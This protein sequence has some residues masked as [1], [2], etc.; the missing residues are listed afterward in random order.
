MLTN[1]RNWGVH[2]TFLNMYE[3]ICIPKK[4]LYGLL[5]ELNTFKIES[6][7]PQFRNK[8]SLV[9][10]KYFRENFNSLKQTLNN[11]I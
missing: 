4:G 6:Y 10:E 11:N 5:T 8:I 9:L 3:L 7:Y 2:F 1:H